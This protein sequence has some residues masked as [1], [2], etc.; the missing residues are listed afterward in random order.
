MVSVGE[1]R[2]SRADPQRKEEGF[3]GPIFQRHAVSYTA[4]AAAAAAA[5]AGIDLGD[6]ATL[7]CEC[8]LDTEKTATRW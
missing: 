7:T 5:A 4:A 2:R 1:S 8:L 3:F 6:H